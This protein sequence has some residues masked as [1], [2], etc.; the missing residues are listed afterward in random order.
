M[1]HPVAEGSPAE[2]RKNESFIYGVTVA[3]KQSNTTGDAYLDSIVNS[4][5]FA[6]EMMMEA[7]SDD[8]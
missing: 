1:A 4:S 6:R 3:T 7:E 2:Q 8:Q 5:R